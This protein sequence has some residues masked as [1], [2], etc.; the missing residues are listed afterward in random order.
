MKQFYKFLLLLFLSLQVN[1]CS[2]DD[3]EVFPTPA[4]YETTEFFIANLENNDTLLYERYEDWC[5]GQLVRGTELSG[6]STGDYFYNHYGW[7]QKLVS[8]YYFGRNGVDAGFGSLNNVLETG[9]DI[10]NDPNVYFVVG[11]FINGDYYTS[12]VRSINYID[13]VFFTK[14]D[15]AAEV[16]T[17]SDLFG[18]L[19]NECR[20]SNAFLLRTELNYNGHLYRAATL[21]DSVKVNAEITFN[22]GVSR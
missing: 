1:G 12:H 2:P 21:T 5:T 3:D 18:N 9:V 8:I 16:M 13:G 4:E 20:M 15:P 10:F 14:T 19:E 17:T 7:G 11:C 22:V 6:G